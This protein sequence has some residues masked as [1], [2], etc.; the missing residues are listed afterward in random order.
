M[1]MREASEGNVPV[2]DL[3]GRFDA[4]VAPSVNQWIDQATVMEPARVIVDLSNVNF[5]DSIAL[6]TLVRAMKRCRQH[7]GDLYLCGLQQSVRIIFEL[8]RLDKAFTLFADRNQAL[9]AIPG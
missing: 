7:K 1:T 5:I 6:A 4:H 9:Q 2:L 8:T 3:A